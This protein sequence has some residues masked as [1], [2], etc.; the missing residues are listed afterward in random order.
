LAAFCALLQR[1]LKG[2]WVG[3]ICIP[4]ARKI[5]PPQTRVDM[6]GSS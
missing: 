5:L 6:L 1:L 3:S 4:K 2:L